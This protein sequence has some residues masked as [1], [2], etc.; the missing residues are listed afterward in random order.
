MPDNVGS[1]LVK[2]KKIM[3]KNQLFHMVD[4]GKAWCV[5]L[6]LGVM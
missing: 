6:T 1:V 5:W 3:R 2:N 4:K